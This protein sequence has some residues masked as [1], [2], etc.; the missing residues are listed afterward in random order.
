MKAIP[1][2]ADKRFRRK[3]NFYDDL[4][5]QL[6][7]LPTGQALPVT[8]SDSFRANLHKRMAGRDV[9]NVRT[10]SLPNGQFAV[11]IDEGSNDLADTQ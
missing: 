11:W 9:P 8:G 2:P 4:A 6:R 3:G 1:I 10:A 5:A 7:R